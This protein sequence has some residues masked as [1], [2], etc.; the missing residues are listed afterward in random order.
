MTKSGLK[1]FIY[2][3]LLLSGISFFNPFSIIS[4]EVAKLIQYIVVLFAF[5]ISLIWGVSVD[6]RSYPKGAYV[7]IIWGM[8]ISIFMVSL[9]HDQGFITSIIST[10]PYLF[11]YLSFYVLLRLNIPKD[12][13]LNFIWALCF[14]SMI[15][16]VINTITFPN[17]IFGEIKDEYDDSRGFVRLSIFC[18]ELIVLLFFY[19]INQWI[20]TKK[21]KFCFLVGL[22]GLF[23]FMS[24]TR[25]YILFASV[26]G[27]WMF[28]RNVSLIKKLLAT[29][30][31]VLIIY[32]VL[33]QIPLVNTL[34]DLTEK[35]FTN[36]VNFEEDVRIR[37]WRFYTYQFQTNA[38]TPIFGNGIPTLGGKS[39]W[40]KQYESFVS[41]DYG[42]NGCFTH[43]VGWAG[44]FWYFGA[45][46]TIGLFLLLF[47][48]IKRKKKINEQYLTY[49]CIFICFIS[50]ASAPI[51]Y[52]NQILSIT[53]VLY[54]IY[55]QNEIDCDNY[56]KL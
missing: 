52:Y 34:M 41:Y 13:I 18:L 55:G 14:I 23:I 29:V 49:W 32:L 37:A 33:P 31:C 4:P 26:L 11:G 27:I 17:I 19:S 51:M 2:T 44:F 25:Q 20:V 16:Y 48:A 46:S 21:N 35:Q 5:F 56:S 36:S 40:G 12:R 22:S 6:R 43:D 54:L 38:I 45:I 10:L 53:S 24:L 3:L 8:I 30:S 1:Y 42:G 15:I 7:A 9:F 39:N 47:K 28:L 50:V